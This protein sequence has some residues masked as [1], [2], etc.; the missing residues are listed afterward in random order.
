MHKLN[1]VVVPLELGDAL[2]GMVQ[3]IEEACHC[4]FIS[5]FNVGTDHVEL[6]LLEVLFH[7]LCPLTKRLKLVEKVTRVV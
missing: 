7:G 2:D 4:L 6:H 3:A 5:L 1:H